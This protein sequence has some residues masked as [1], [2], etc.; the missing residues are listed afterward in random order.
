ME[1]RLTS[2]KSGRLPHVIVPA[3]PERIAKELQ[4]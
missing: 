2:A 1:L 3:A 4:S